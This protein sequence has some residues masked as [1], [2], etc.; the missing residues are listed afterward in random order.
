MHVG[1]TYQATYHDDA[2]KSASRVITKITNKRDA[3]VICGDG[4][5]PREMLKYL[6]KECGKRYSKLV[7][8]A[9]YEQLKLRVAWPKQINQPCV[10][11]DVT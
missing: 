11:K 1:V 6:E 7:Y 4:I 8:T 5:T 2:K 3:E 9:E 10:Y